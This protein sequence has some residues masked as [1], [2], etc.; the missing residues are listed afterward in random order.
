MTSPYPHQTGL[1]IA[2]PLTGRA[3]PPYWS[4]AFLNLHPPMNYAVR[5]LTNFD[6]THKVM[7]GPVDDIRNWYVAQAIE[8][9]CKYLFFL[10]EDVTVPGHALRQLIFQMEHHPEAAV[11]AGIYCHKAEPPMPMVFRG[12]G[13]GPYWDWKVGEFFEISGCGMGATLLRVEAFK[14]LEPPYFKTVDDTSP[15]LDGKNAAEVWT[16]DLYCVPAGQVVYGDMLPIERHEVGSRVLTDKRR[17]QSVTKVFE[18]EYVGPLVRFEPHYGCGFEVTPNHPV[19]VSRD[20]EHLFVRAD[21]VTPRDALVVPIQT[22]VREDRVD[23]LPS[24]PFIRGKFV[25]FKDASFRYTRTHETAHWFPL[26]VPVTPDFCRLAGY[27]VAE[28]SVSGSLTSETNT[29][30]FTFH[31]DEIE[32]VKDVRT[33]LM[34]LFGLRST[35]DVRAG[36]KCV[37]IVAVS[38]PLADLLTGYFGRRSDT[39]TVPEEIV[40]GSPECTKAFLRGYWRGDGSKDET[41]SLSMATVSQ[42][43]AHAVRFMLIRLGIYSSWYEKAAGEIF[44]NGKTCPTLR[45]YTIVPVAQCQE[46]WRSILGLRARTIRRKINSPWLVRHLRPGGENDTGGYFEV[47][48][49][50]ITP[51]EHAGRVYNLSVGAD[52]TYNVHGFAVHNCCE[53]LAGTDWKLYADASVLCDHWDMTTMIPTRIPPESKPVKRLE[54]NGH[55][56]VVDLGSGEDPYQAQEGEVVVTVDLRDEAKPDYRCDLRRLP[57]ANETFSKVFSSHTLEH[58][59]RNEVDAVL[60]EW[61]RI[62]KP[63]GEIQLNLPNIGW[64]ADEIQAG[65]ITNDVLNVLYGAQSYDLNYHKCGFTP[66]TVRKMLEARGFEVE[67]ATRGYNILAVGRNRFKSKTP[68]KLTNGKKRKQVK[69]K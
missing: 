48:L 10:D 15:F 20:G 29:V 44:L 60:D 42:A 55:R 1:M 37:N 50:G 63:D 56:R 23:T 9:K 24:W 43:L 38:T 28:G 66:Q 52:H 53:K 11:I 2:V 7:A 21:G 40:T 16:E 6:A 65:R 54:M 14:G 30:N 51:V 13:A 46:V 41:G 18:R 4:W 32:Y 59:A 45:V 49:K 26:S 25:E 68:L 31:E 39:K 61:V 67:I 19:L 58:F 64:A 62:L 47:A 8:Q 69:R 36:S 27:W 12:N 34:D 57:F 35:V 33:L 3:L 22:R 5:Y 17:L